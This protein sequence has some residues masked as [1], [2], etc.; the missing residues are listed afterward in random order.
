MERLFE[1]ADQDGSGSI[2]FHEFCVM[3]QAMN[4]N[5]EQPE[6]LD[7]ETTLLEDVQK[8]MTAASVL[9]LSIQVPTGV[10][11]QITFSCYRQL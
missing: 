11:P 4:P 5:H 7:G 6:D 2:E 10:Y 1:E 3:I 8:T 9:D